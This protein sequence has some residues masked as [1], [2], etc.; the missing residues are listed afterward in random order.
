MLSNE[1]SISELDKYTI[2]LRFFEHKAG[3]SPKE[4]IVID[5]QKS[6]VKALLK[7]L[8]NITNKEY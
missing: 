1:F 3:F 2:R 6:K 5:F 4:T 7:E 8:N